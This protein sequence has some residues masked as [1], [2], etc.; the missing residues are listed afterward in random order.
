MLDK[1]KWLKPGKW[2]WVVQD[3]DK[4]QQFRKIAIFLEFN[5]PGDLPPLDC[6]VVWKENDQF[7]SGQVAVNELIPL[8]NCTGWNY[9]P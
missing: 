1:I 8:N 6:W 9:M 3:E 5:N 4:T 7:I 2:V